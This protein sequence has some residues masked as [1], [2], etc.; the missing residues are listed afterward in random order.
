[1]GASVQEVFD[2]A[3]KIHDGARKMPLEMT[4]KGGGVISLVFLGTVQRQ[5]VNSAARIL[6]SSKFLPILPRSL[7]R[8]LCKNPSFQGGF[9]D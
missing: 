7:S 2:C 1:M 4:L 5:K 6:H 3:V 9:V 8:S